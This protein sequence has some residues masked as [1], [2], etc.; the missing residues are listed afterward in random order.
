MFVSNRNQSIDF[1]Y[2]SMDW[3]LYDRDQI[4]KG[5]QISVFIGGFELQISYTQYSCL[6]Y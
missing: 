2:K 3:F 6:T 5:L 1:L 4:Y